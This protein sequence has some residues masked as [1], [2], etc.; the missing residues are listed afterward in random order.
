MEYKQTLNKVKALL[1]IEV[2]LEQVKLVDGVTTLE[3]E[4]FEA[5]YSVGIVTDEGAIPAPIGSYET[6]DGMIIT[7][8]VEGQIMSV[9]P[10]EKD[11]EVE[12]EVEAKTDAQPVA[13]KVVDTVTKE[14][15]FEEVK[16]EIEKLEN[17]NKALKT[18]L[19]AL[20]I[21]LSEASAKAIVPNPESNVKRELTPLEIYREIKK[22]MK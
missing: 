3:A 10:K 21:E 22:N 2:K 5:G 15:F 11:A 17:E 7:V 16:V 4:S 19:A 1:S 14:T 6:V 13:K 20:K 8:E 18:E 12:V 9:T